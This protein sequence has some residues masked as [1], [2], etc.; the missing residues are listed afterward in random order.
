M[1]VKHKQYED[2]FVHSGCRPTPQAMTNFWLMTNNQTNIK[3]NSHLPHPSSP[4]SS[5]PFLLSL[6]FICSLKQWLWHLRMMNSFS[7]L[8]FLLRTSH[9]PSCPR[10]CRWDRD[11]W[12]YFAICVHVWVS[13]GIVGGGVMQWHSEISFGVGGWRPTHLQISSQPG[14]L[15]QTQEACWR[16]VTGPEREERDRQV[17]RQMGWI[18]SWQWYTY[19]DCIHISECDFQI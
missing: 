8:T 7:A 19:W 2:W 14:R 13:V 18:G 3:P 17:D 1:M 6:P 9:P 11:R 16:A 15:I 4:H 12:R 10:P 5:S